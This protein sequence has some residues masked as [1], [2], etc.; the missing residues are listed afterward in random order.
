MP[1]SP[2]P[3]VTKELILQR[4]DCKQLAD[5]KKLDLSN[6]GLENIDGNL[7]SQMPNLQDLN[8][9]KNKLAAFP[10]DLG[11]GKLQ[12]LDVS[13]NNLRS[14]L[15][16]AQFQELE[17]VNIHD[18]P[19]TAADREQLTFLLP[20]IKS[21]DGDTIQDNHRQYLKRVF[22]TSLEEKVELLWETQ[23]KSLFKKSQ[24]AGVQ[25][26]LQDQ[27]IQRAK[28]KIQAGPASMAQLR[29]WRIE[30]IASKLV[31]EQDLKI[32]RGEAS[33][34]SKRSHEESSTNGVS[35]EAEAP[36]KKPRNVTFNDKVVNAAEK[37]S[38]TVTSRDGRVKVDLLPKTLGRTLA[39]KVVPKPAS[40]KPSPTL[41]K[42]S[43]ADY[44][45][46]HI[47][48]CHSL[49]NNRDD[50]KTMVWKCVFEPNPDKTEESTSIVATCGGESVCLLDCR[51]GKVVQKF[52][53]PKEDFF[54]VVWMTIPLD[55]KKEK[56]TNILVVGGKK[57][58]FYLIHPQQNIWYAE[59]EAHRRDMCSMVVHPDQPTWL[60][61][62]S[63]DKTIRLWDISPP[64]LPNYECRIK[65]LAEWSPP[66]IPLHMLLF[67]GRN[68]LLAAC[69]SGCFGF[70]L[71]HKEENW[72][73]T[74]T[75]EFTFP[76]VE[77]CTEDGQ[78][79]ETEFM[80][81]MT[82]ISPDVIASK[83]V[84]HGCIYLWNLPGTLKRSAKIKVQGPQ[85]LKVQPVAHLEWSETFIDY[86]Y[87]KMWPGY[88]VLVC[89]DDVG[90]TWMYDV[91]KF[92]TRKL[93]EDTPVPP[94]QKLF[95]PDCTW[96]GTRLSKESDKDEVPTV[97]SPS[98]SMS[99]TKVR[100][101]PSVNDIA[102]SS[103]GDFIVG[104]TDCNLVF[105]WRKNKT[106]E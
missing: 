87:F 75:T 81:N 36:S 89:G 77:K 26:L 32:A 69:R 16:L 33:M 82:L 55:D 19:Y 91:S 8:L 90:N 44:E 84:G 83:L 96:N 99:E 60:Y 65:K 73:K 10:E 6:L 49:K 78:E 94:A 95:W 20:K 23:Y 106:V 79:V 4:T 101:L 50:M 22:G 70:K 58:K 45:P 5:V 86:I 54:C 105:M 93:P 31:A 14:F 37:S 21:V 38:E 97:V 13:E 72:K 29:D 2:A 80:D 53:Q 68:L 64:K 71:N 34:S 17:Q 28:Q 40:K 9:S 85:T 104:V 39:K 61:T 15:S 98:S 100:L 51:T 62:G 66:S 59:H 63:Y 11:L 42:D 35:S 48:Q 43:T 47:L 41:S 88:D 76:K 7:F 3:Q 46:S 18:N 74:Y 56:M 52:S 25:R 12:V 102:I 103:T 30:T 24:S 1:P 57:G 92:L 27:F 67:P